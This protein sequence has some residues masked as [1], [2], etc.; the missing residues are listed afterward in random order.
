M[1][2][3][4]LY[5]QLKDLAADL[6][7]VSPLGW[8][9]VRKALYQPAIN[10][11]QAAI[12]RRAA[13][14]A[15]ARRMAL[16][17]ND[18]VL[19]PLRNST[20]AAVQAELARLASIPV[21]A[22]QPNF[23]IR[24]VQG[25]FRKV[26]TRRA[27]KGKDSHLAI[28]RDVNGQPSRITYFDNAQVVPM[29][30]ARFPGPPSQEAMRAHLARWIASGQIELDEGYG[31]HNWFWV[32]TGS[33]LSDLDMKQPFPED[34]QLE[35]VQLGDATDDEILAAIETQALY[36]SVDG[37]C[38]FDG[39]IEVYAGSS[40]FKNMTRDSL[41]AEFLELDPSCL[42]EGKYH[43]NTAHI[44]KW[45]KKHHLSM[46]VGDYNGRLILKRGDWGK[47]RFK[48]FVYTIN[49]SHLEVATT[50]QRHALMTYGFVQRASTDMYG[51]PSIMEQDDCHD[52]LVVAATQGHKID[53]IKF[54]PHHRAVS[55]VDNTAE[56]AYV[57]RPQAKRDMLAWEAMYKAGIVGK[58]EAGSSMARLSRTFAAYYIDMPK[59]CLS[60]QVEASLL[61][62]PG[63]FKFIGPAYEGPVRSFDITKAHTCAL[64]F[65]RHRWGFFD[66]LSQWQTVKIDEDFAV[67]QGARYKVDKAID[68][69]GIKLAKG[70]NYD[71]EFIEWGLEEGVFDL[72]DITSVLL[73]TSTLDPDFAREMVDKAYETDYG[74]AI[75][76]MFIG[77]L[78]CHAIN[79][80]YGYLTD[81]FR[82]EL[83]RRQGKVTGELA[84]NIFVVHEVETK[85]IRQ[86][87]LPM[88]RAI[89]EAC[90]VMLAR[91]TK[92]AV[93]G[94]GH[95]H[96]FI[97]DCIVGTNLPDLEG[98]RLF[99]ENQ[100]G[101]G[102]IRMEE[103]KPRSLTE[104]YPEYR[105]G[106]RPKPSGP[107][108]TTQFRAKTPDDLIRDGGMVLGGPGTGKS[109]M[110]ANK[111]LPRCKELGLRTKVC[112]P[113]HAAVEVLRKSGIQATT[114]QKLLTSQ[115]PDEI[116]IIRL[117]RST[118]VLI[119]DEASMLGVDL[120]KAMAIAHQFGVRIIIIGD[121]DQLPAVDRIN[122]KFTELEMFRNMC[123]AVMRLT[124][125]HRY[126]AAL[127]SK[128]KDILDG[129]AV[130]GTPICG[131][132]LEYRHL[133]Y[134]NKTV[135]AINQQCLSVY[136]AANPNIED[137]DEW[138]AGAPVICRTNELP[139]TWNGRRSFIQADRTVDGI[140][141]SDD[142]LDKHFSLG[143]ASTV[144]KAQ[145]QT[146]T[147][148]LA[149]HECSKM[150]INML[151]TA[152]SRATSLNNV[153]TDCAAVGFRLCWGSPSDLPARHLKTQDVIP[154]VVEPDSAAWAEHDLR[155]NEL[156]LQKLERKGPII[157]GELLGKRKSK[158]W[159]VGKNRSLEQALEEAK[160]FQLQMY[161]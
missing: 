97:T 119:V 20:I 68:Y 49:F 98:Q 128:L 4:D 159:R 122:L 111:L 60:D 26:V 105:F 110:L 39:I 10:E 80:T 5:A 130:Q 59:S 89:V 131:D 72:L 34:I 22:D 99:P 106:W 126:D 149:I 137:G 31:K 43:I 108:H 148:K 142:E 155:H 32:P 16:A 2:K 61:Q 73:P 141:Y 153:H 118:D 93:N 6:N 145:G 96:E 18:E 14:Y 74:K 36:A 136:K 56:K 53:H 154:V 84:P 117:M 102:V 41:K 76:N 91:M 64:Y 8:I 86:N 161:T 51:L 139:G 33:L 121:P 134:T 146:I 50:S 103:L 92:M 27:R 37:E 114:A 113:T 55:F 90:I 81:A 65:R 160:A 107:Y 57:A 69:H 140:E 9:G 40:Y 15:Q 143:W 44:A 67:V 158:K 127:A 12:Q 66:V 88:Y 48:S 150:S 152:W 23:I 75:V 71:S 120:G 129:E 19:I 38:V 115:G 83:A 21:A 87:N 157:K 70:H 63:A 94:G 3:S 24:P 125:V 135:N 78:G 101:F 25:S 109:H 133:A 116:P 124:K 17:R 147:G 79:P 45:C 29:I 85:R 62:C 112:A 52:E 1:S 47:T 42:R 54:G 151:Y 82:A 28:Y 11:L 7:V 144:H 30:T 35:A 100:H 46:A 156:I 13:L 104:C 138:P 123:P 58:D 77:N 95:V 132:I